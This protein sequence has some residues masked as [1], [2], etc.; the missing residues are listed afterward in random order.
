MAG[1]RAGPPACPGVY[2]FRDAA[3]RLLYVGASGNLAR[4]VQSYFAPRHARH[5]KE[6]RITQLAT[7]LE[8]APAGSVVEALVHEARLIRRERPYFNRRLKEV[9]R[10]VYARVDLRDP[11]PRFD[12]T[13]TLAEGPYRYLGPFASRARLLCALDILA[14]ALGLRT[15]PGTL[16][17]DAQG[18]ACLRLDLRQCSAPCVARTTAGDYGRRVVQAFAALGDANDLVASRR[19]VPAANLSLPG[20]VAS[21]ARALRSARLAATVLVVLPAAGVPGHRVLAIVAGRLRAAEAAPDGAALATA[22]QRALRAFAGPVDPVVSRAE[23]DEVRLL[24]A[25][26]ASPSGRQATIEV[27][28]CSAEEAWRHL[29]ART[30]VGPL[31]DRPMPTGRPAP[32]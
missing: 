9:G 29:C 8:W 23:I 32:R 14:D 4:R 20:A 31:F 27:T 5:G 10:Y 25:W 6:G 3:G 17:P 30:A 11:F 28:S 1:H 12:L 13:G 19:R 24:T 18:R 16:T 2:A 15:C 26:L 22:F 21:A 7:R